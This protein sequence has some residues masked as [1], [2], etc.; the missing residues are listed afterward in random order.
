MAPANLVHFI[1]KHQRVL[2]AYALECLDDLPGER[3]VYQ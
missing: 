2:G 3:S 1:N